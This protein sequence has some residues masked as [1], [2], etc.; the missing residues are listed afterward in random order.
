M[1]LVCGFLC[2]HV[3]RKAHESIGCSCFNAFSRVDVR[4]D[5]KI[6]GGVNAYVIDVRGERSVQSLSLCILVK[7]TDRPVVISR[8][9]ATPELWQ[10]TY[11]SAVLR[12]ILYADDVNYRLAGYR[13]IDPI[14]SPEAEIRFLQTAE[15]L[16]MKGSC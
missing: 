6:P 15:A 4:I 3:A 11:L 13:K 9:E 10:E 8:H 5:V 14:T 2:A 1:L 12:A 16:F 7:R